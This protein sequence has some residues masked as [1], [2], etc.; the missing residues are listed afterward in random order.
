MRHPTRGPQAG[1]EGAFGAEGHGLQLASQPTM[2][3]CHRAILSMLSSLRFRSLI[4][5]ATFFM[6]SYAAFMLS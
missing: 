6:A 4:R 3:T 1:G 5:Q 2:D